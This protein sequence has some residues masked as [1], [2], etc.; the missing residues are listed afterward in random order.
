MAKLRTK[1]D[2]ALF[3]F[4]RKNAQILWEIFLNLSA[5]LYAYDKGSWDSCESGPS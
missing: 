3:K 4:I 1:L 2:M 5:K